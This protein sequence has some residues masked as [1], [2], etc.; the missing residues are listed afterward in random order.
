MPSSLTCDQLIAGYEPGLPIVKGASLA[1]VPGEIHAIFGPNGAGKSTLVKAIAGLVPISGGVVQLDGR[2]ITTLPAHRMIHEGLAF[3]PQTE[4]IFAELTVL[5][6]IELA[7]AILKI[8][9]KARMAELDALFPDLTRLR[10]LKAGRLS[11]GQ[12]QML[13]CARALMA[14]PRVLILD[15]PSAGLSPKLVETVFATLKAVCATG[16]T[17][18]L[19]EQNVKAA[20]TIANRA[21]VLVDGHERLTALA[22][23]LHDPKR[24]AALY[25]SHGDDPSQDAA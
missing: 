8:D 19:V 24:L 7:A 13:A 21:T 15:E 9:R 1:V 22:A 11:G 10:H 12:R 18:V 2:A 23:D 6:N 16:V 4:N 20:L 17:I 3:V 5:E 14:R 25:F